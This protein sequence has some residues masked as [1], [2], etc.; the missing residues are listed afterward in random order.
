MQNKY[1]QLEN[2][3]IKLI[4]SK[5]RH[6]NIDNLLNLHIYDLL[7]VK[8]WLE[9]RIKEDI[10]ITY[11]LLSAFIF[12]NCKDRFFRA[13]QLRYREIKID[14]DFKNCKYC[15]KELNRKARESVHDFTKRKF[16]NITCSAKLN[17]HNLREKLLNDIGVKKCEHC[18]NTIKIRNNERPHRFVFRRFC[19][20]SCRAFAIRINPKIKNVE[21]K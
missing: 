11:T 4:K 15:S 17:N 19:C 20:R 1:K 8:K 7:I 10:E 21:I 2:D 3:I 13:E 18:S 16:C 14:I 9:K 12:K 5:V 6:P